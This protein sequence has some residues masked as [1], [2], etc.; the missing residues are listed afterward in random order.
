MPA[1]TVNGGFNPPPSASAVAAGADPSPTTSLPHWFDIA[2]R[3]SGAYDLT[4]QGR[5]VLKFGVNRY[6][7]PQSTSFGERYNPIAPAQATLPWVDRNRNDVADDGEFDLALLPTN[8]GERSLNIPAAGASSAAGTWKPR[9][10]IQHEVMRGLVA[11]VHWYRR[12]FHDF[13]QTDNLLS[14][15]TDYRPVTIINPLDGLPLAIFDVVNS[16]VLSRVDNFDSNYSGEPDLDPVCSALEVEARV[17]LP[18][19]GS[20]F[21]GWTM[22]RTREVNC[23]PLDNPDLRFCDQTGGDGEAR[24]MALLPEA[25]RSPT[26]P[27]GSLPFEHQIEDRGALPASV[28]GFRAESRLAEL[29]WRSDGSVLAALANG[30]LPG[31]E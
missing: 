29:S 25:L 15:V 1:R 16:S 9:L 12:T 10:G 20:V 13:A 11:G 6:N 5:T 27:T 8:F 26:N 28:V 24:G 17:N 14:A 19:G 3:F 22:D 31:L 4:G 18:G 2:P 21:G 7:E 30:A 23:Q